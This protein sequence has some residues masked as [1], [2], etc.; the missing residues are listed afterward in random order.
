MPT[1][2]QL[3]E[4]LIV[5]LPGQLQDVRI[6]PGQPVP[7]VRDNELDSL[8]SSCDAWEDLEQKRQRLREQAEQAE[9]VEACKCFKALRA[10][11]KERQSGAF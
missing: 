10:M 9:Y 11:V 6:E 5:P 4:I 3:K 1:T 8:P 7:K 2:A